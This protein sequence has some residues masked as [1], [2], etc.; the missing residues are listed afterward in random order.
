METIR[1]TSRQNPVIKRVA[2]LS[3]SKGR[4]EHN[5]FF[6][7]GVKLYREAISEGFVPVEAFVSDSFSGDINGIQAERVYSVPDEV[8]E[9]MTEQSAP[10]GLLCVFDKFAIEPRGNTC[11]LL[12]ENMQD[13]GNLGTVLR[14]A[15]AFGCR[16][17]VGVS[18]CDPFSP[19]TVRAS[20]GAIFKVPYRAFNTLSDALEYVGSTNLL[21]TALTSEAVPLDSVSLEG[22]CIMIGNEGHGLS[23]EALERSDKQVI[24]PIEQVESLNASVAASIILYEA[25]R[26]RRG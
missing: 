5:A 21:A 25:S 6:T 4:G 16:E 13:P 26:R 2:S 11:T 8:Y 17:V 23:D 9:K 24:I 1:I 10:E 7:E 12:L 14:S 19:K 3:S 18:S 20:M 15:A 22:A